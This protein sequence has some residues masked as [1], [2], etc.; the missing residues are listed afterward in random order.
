M[1]INLDSRILTFLNEK[2]FDNK[3]CFCRTCHSHLIKNT[4]PPCAVAN[5]MV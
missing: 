3:E 1:M 2:S 4:V 5:G